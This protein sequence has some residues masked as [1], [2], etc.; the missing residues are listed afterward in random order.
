MQAFVDNIKKMNQNVFSN[1]KVAKAQ[2]EKTEKRLTAIEHQ[3]NRIHN[4]TTQ[5]NNFFNSTS[6]SFKSMSPSVRVEDN[7]PKI[8][9]SM[10][11]KWKRPNN[12]KKVHKNYNHDQ[13]LD[14]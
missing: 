1:L 11:P 2:G 14:N 7:N 12:K 6:R 5:A 4:H 10:N 9:N 13:Y 8:K 3:R